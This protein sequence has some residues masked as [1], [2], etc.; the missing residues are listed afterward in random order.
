MMR[1]LVVGAG[2]VGGHFGTLLTRAGVDVTFLVREA[3]AER[4]RSD[5][6]ALVA[7]DGTRT[8][9]PVAT[10]TARS[11][12]EPFDVVLLAVKSTAVAAALDDVAPAIGP[13]TAIVP[14]LNGID[15]LA[16]I[17]ERFGARHLLGGVCLVATQVDSDGAIRQLTPAATI[18]V[19][20]LSGRVTERVE[21]ITKTFAPAHFE[22]VASTTIEQDMW[23]KWLF[24]AA[25]G[26]AT[27]LLGAHVGQINPVKDGTDAIHDVIAETA[28]VLEAA[29]HP[30]REDALGNVTATL[31]SPGSMF[32]TS[33]YRDFRDNRA[34]EVEPIIGGLCR[35]GSQH[36][37]STPLLRAAA[38]RLRV[39]EAG[40]A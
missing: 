25:G 17:G 36:G 40:L 8:T 23:E 19:G 3:R 18:T 26:A 14:L 4:L 22:T 27:V 13:G 34:T 7:P 24:M 10:V 9:T 28:S 32:A 30:A 37:V 29:G 5:G 1:V 12:R 38:V 33:L 2:A 20:E 31:T 39:H 11:L 15:H 16:A 35:V 6:V 21:A